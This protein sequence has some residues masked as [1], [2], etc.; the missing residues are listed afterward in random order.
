MALSLVRRTVPLVL[1]ATV[2]GVI[3]SGQAFA[4]PPPGEWTVST[5]PA[6]TQPA[7]LYGISAPRPDTAWAVGSEANGTGPVILR[8]DGR[9]WSRTP[10]PAGTAPE[11]V[12]VAA[13]GPERA[14][15][16]GQSG[17]AGDTRALRWNGRAWKAV[18]YPSDLPLAL[19]VDSG[20]AAWSVGCA[21]GISDCAVLHHRNGAWI[22]REP[23]FA[24]APLTVAARTPG[25]VW[26][27]GNSEGGRS[28]L[29]RYNGETW[30]PVSFPSQWPTMVLQILPV[31]AD[32]VWVYTLPFD[33]DFSGPTLMHWDGSTWTEHRPPRPG[34]SQPVRA[35]VEDPGFLG[36]IASDGRGG[37]WLQTNQTGFHQHFDGTDW[38]EVPRSTPIPGGP[39]IYDLAQVG[40]TRSIWGAGHGAGTPVIERFR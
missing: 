30:E 18:P 17:E 21:G 8:W 31:A 13:R 27:G 39:V 7:A 19:S 10:V 36:N 2:P 37:I 3:F 16:I 22:R 4:A 26:I 6:L 38:T 5:P 25:D 29:G 11:L 20:G 40:G 12:D 15:A 35:F 32:D 33:P 9:A 23:G 28:P 34:G 24:I 14:W 1:A